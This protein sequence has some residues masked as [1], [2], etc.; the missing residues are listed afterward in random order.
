MRDSS[1]PV[2]TAF[3]PSGGQ[4]AVCLQWTGGDRVWDESVQP[5]KVTLPADST[6]VQ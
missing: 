4:S 5:V 1:D 6:E 3:M 2:A